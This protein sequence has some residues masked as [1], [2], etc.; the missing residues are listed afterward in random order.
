MPQYDEPLGLR[1]TAT[2]LDVIRE[3]PDYAPG[4]R[5]WDDRVFHPDQYTDKDQ[6][7]STFWE[8]PPRFIERIFS[9]MRLMENAWVR[10]AVQRA[11]RAQCE[12]NLPYDLAYGPVYEVVASTAP[13]E[14]GI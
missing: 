10:G 7:I 3:Y 14:E 12:L 2:L 1:T 13:M 6:P 5:R 4:C 8:A 9:V 11:C